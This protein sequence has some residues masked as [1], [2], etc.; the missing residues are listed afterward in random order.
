MA[1]LGLPRQYQ[2]GPPALTKAD[3]DASFVTP[4]NDFLVTTKV[5]ADNIQNLSLNSGNFS[6]FIITS[7]KIVAG[8]LDATKM[9]DN[10]GL[11]NIHFTSQTITN[12]SRSD[13]TLTT[14]GSDPG[15]GGIASTYDTPTSGLAS[16]NSVT[17]YA[18]ITNQSATITTTGRPVIIYIE[19]N[20]TQ[21]NTISGNVASAGIAVFRGS[22]NI[23]NVAYIDGN[24]DDG[25]AR[26]IGPG[27]PTRR[28]VDLG[29]QGTAS[30]YTYTL[31][32]LSYNGG[33]GTTSVAFSYTD[34][35]M[36]LYEQ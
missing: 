25:D 8:A 36:A 12:S 26:R 7:S 34:F 24:A 23:G 1:E 18:N 9:S 15:A 32:R 16:W 11:T 30:T 35:K 2:D 5:N 17:D 3:L 33:T 22:T 20:L 21:V 10:L 6:D 14:N 4:L 31:K 13:M 29:V 19:G 27:V 28:V